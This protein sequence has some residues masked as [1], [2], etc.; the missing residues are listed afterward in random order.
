MKF[1]P[2]GDDLLVTAPTDVPLSVLSLRVFGPIKINT[3]G[4]SYEWAWKN[5]HDACFD[6]I[7]YNLTLSGAI[8]DDRLLPIGHAETK[9]TI[10]DVVAFGPHGYECSANLGAAS[11]IG[12]ILARHLVKTKST[13]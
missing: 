6:G 8:T 1:T 13:M 9:T 5:L 10:P 12:A 7:F 3:V 4:D 11:E 2:D